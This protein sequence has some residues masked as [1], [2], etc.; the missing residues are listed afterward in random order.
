[1]KLRLKE[2]EEY[3]NAIAEIEVF[4]F[5]N[6]YRT[7][8]VREIKNI[9]LIATSRPDTGPAPAVRRSASSLVNNISQTE[10]NINNL[11]KIPLKIFRQAWK[12][13]SFPRMKSSS[14]L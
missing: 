13:R 7:H 2:R 3:V 14:A 9:D 10:Q 1:M 6:Q 8:K 4:P 5:E 11:P 12:I